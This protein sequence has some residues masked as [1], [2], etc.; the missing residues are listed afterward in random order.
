MRD[1][2]DEQVREFIEDVRRT[3]VA[4]FEILRELREI[5]FEQH[6]GATEQIEYGGITF[7]LEERFGGIFVYSE[8]VSFEFSEGHRFDDPEGQLEGSGESRR[9]LKFETVEDVGEKDPASYV[10]Q[11]G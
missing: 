7:S 5:V 10:E 9:H 6:P 2:D 11:A 1:S 4:Q 3:D 8:H